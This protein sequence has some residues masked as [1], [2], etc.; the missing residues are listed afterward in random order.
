MV[1]D[2]GSIKWVSLMLPEHVK[3]LRDWQDEEEHPRAVQ[4]ALDE[5]KN[6]ELNLA[7]YEALHHDLA[8]RFTYIEHGAYKALKGQI[9]TINEVTRQLKIIDAADRKHLLKIDAILD[10]SFD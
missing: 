7:V 1:Q 10:I 6:E 9:Q 2:R 8:V 4:P 3:M 5:Q